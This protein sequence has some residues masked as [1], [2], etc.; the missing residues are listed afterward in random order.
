MSFADDR[1]DTPAE[2]EY[3]ESAAIEE[4]SK[5]KPGANQA[6]WSAHPHPVPREESVHDAL[7][8]GVTNGAKE[9]GKAIEEK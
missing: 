2:K 5:K 8:D 3:L 9:L 4:N 1:T 6:Q 7:V